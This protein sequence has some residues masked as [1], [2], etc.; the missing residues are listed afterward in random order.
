MV[1]L[2]DREVDVL[3]E[4]VLSEKSMAQERPWLGIRERRRSSKKV[5]KGSETQ[6]ENHEN[7]WLPSEEQV[8]KKDSDQLC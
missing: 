7:L 6:E 4:K 5:E 8:N 3:W 2:K 1:I